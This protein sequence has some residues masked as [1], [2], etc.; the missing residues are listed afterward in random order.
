MLDLFLKGRAGR[1]SPFRGSARVGLSR[2]RV[3]ASAMVGGV[4]KRPRLCTGVVGVTESCP[5]LPDRRGVTTAVFK[6]AGATVAVRRPARPLRNRGGGG[7]G[8]LRAKTRGFLRCIFGD[9]VGGH[10]GLEG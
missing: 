1:K 5:R 9:P 6:S 3:M 8:R 10:F 7:L 4:S 2:S